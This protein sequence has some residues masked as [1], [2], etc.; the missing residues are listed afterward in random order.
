MEYGI[1]WI[2][3]M[4]TSLSITTLAVAMFSSFKHRLWRH[5]GI[6]TIIGGL[7]FI[8]GIVSLF[9]GLMY[10][11]NLIL[12]SWLF[13]Y[14]TSF[15]LIYLI[16]ALVILRR[17][18]SVNKGSIPALDWNKRILTFSLFLGMILTLTTY[19]L[20]DSTFGIEHGKHKYGL[21]S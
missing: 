5:L 1:L 10:Y 6:L 4:L 19:Y 7:I 16:A 15:S 21:I 8:F 17:G 20:I 11:N 3:A 2:F 12:P 18:F 13:P 14:T 9:T